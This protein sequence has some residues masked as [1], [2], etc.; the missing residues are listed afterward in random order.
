[1]SMKDIAGTSARIE[2]LSVRDT[3]AVEDATTQDQ[4]SE[5]NDRED[6]EGQETLLPNTAQEKVLQDETLRK[7][8]RPGK[9]MESNAVSERVL[10]TSAPRVTIPRAHKAQYVDTWFGGAEEKKN[11]AVGKPKHAWVDVDIDSEEDDWIIL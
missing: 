6:K 10:K 11:T 7:S 3:P 4:R 8:S 5:A 1:M 9:E 2:P